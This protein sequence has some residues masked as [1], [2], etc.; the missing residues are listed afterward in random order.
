MAWGQ[1]WQYG[2]GKGRTAEAAGDRESESDKPRGK[3][4]H[5]WRCQHCG[6]KKTPWA[7]WYCKHC[8][9]PWNGGVADEG[10]ILVVADNDSPP[11]LAPRA[12]GLQP[13]P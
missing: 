11:G 10:A 3:G 4:V 5:T 12:K 9:R 1:S 2:G 13:P 8:S 7:Q 6:C